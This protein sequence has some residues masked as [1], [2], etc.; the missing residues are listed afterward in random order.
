M[1]AELDE[2]E[3]LKLKEKNKAKVKEKVMHPENIRIQEIH[4]DRNQTYKKIP[5]PV[6]FYP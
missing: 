2:E 5:Q 6:L 3:A 1:E 4:F